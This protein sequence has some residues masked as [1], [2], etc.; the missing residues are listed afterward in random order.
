MIIKAARVEILGSG[1]SQGT[2]GQIDFVGPGVTVSVVGNTATI[3]FT[4]PMGA[5]G[6]DG[7]DGQDSMIPGP[8]GQTGAA[9]VVPGPTGP[10]LFMT[11][12]DGE[13]GQDSMI[14][15]PT[16]PQGPASV[17]PGPMGA[18]LFMMAQDGDDGQDSI[19]PGPTGLQGVSGATV[20]NFA[21]SFL[22]MGG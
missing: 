2:A 13:D 3:T 19:I 6:I 12:Q 9:S 15:G 16:G 7:D 10:A 11:A 5:P 4:P 22:L 21:R 18:A 14:P 20:V 8:P 17:V 1:V